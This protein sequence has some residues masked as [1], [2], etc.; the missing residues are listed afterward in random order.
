M[1]K[2]G[3]L[4]VVIDTFRYY[5]TLLVRGET[6]LISKADIDPLREDEIAD[7]ESLTGLEEAGRVAL[8]RLIV[9]KLNGGLGTSMGLS[10]AKSLLEVKGGLTFLD[11]IARQ[12][13]THREKRGVSFPIVFMNSFSTEADTLEALRPYEGLSTGLPLTFVQHRFPKVLQEGLTPAAWP[14]DPE[15][16]WN[17]PGHGDIYTALVTS[18]MLEQLIDAGIRYAFVSNSDNLGAVVDENILGYFA[19]KDFPFMMEV[20]DRTEGDSKGGHL[21]RLKNG[22]LT[23]REIAQCPEDE[24]DAF[25]D[26]HVY[27]YF[28]TNTIWINLL[29]LKRLLE[30]HHNVIHLPMIRNPKTVDPKN[31]STPGV[32]QIETAMGSAVSTFDGAS[33][34]RVPRAR[35]APVKK[36]HDLLALWSDCYV[37]TDDYLVIQNPERKAGPLILKLDGR[38]Y[39]KIDQLRAR[40]PRGTP[41]LVECKSLEVKG[42]VLFGQNVVIRD[43]IIISNHLENQ[44]TIPDGSLIDKDLIFT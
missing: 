8:E 44:V 34:I 38:H 13:L 35:F 11:V 32:Y 33:A 5:Y 3:L 42:D 18:G 24:L 30:V 15:M 36:C 41:S 14:S 17:P 7:A 6:G 25:Q 29:A 23:L 16:E 22:R 40:F 10:K 2:N 26:V 12:I 43:E 20:T 37:L 9:I 21:A 19:E 1:E 27:R 31:D 39:K 4:P 28:N